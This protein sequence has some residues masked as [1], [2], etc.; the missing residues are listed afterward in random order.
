MKLFKYI[1]IF[2]LTLT[3]SSYAQEKDNSRTVR[4]ASGGG[5]KIILGIPASTAKSSPAQPKVARNPGDAGKLNPERAN[6]IPSKTEKRAFGPTEI[7]KDVYVPKFW[8]GKDKGNEKLEIAQ[9]LGHIELNTDKLRIEC[10]DFA[11]VDGDRVRVYLNGVLKKSNVLLD[12][13]YFIIELPL[14]KGFNKIDIQAI[15]QGVSGPNT[16]QF[17]VYDGNGRLVSTKKWNLLTGEAASL[18]VMRK[19]D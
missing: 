4:D 2:S 8:D 12:G 5:E 1:L 17:I 14:E 13:H 3:A 11:Y 7:P 9:Y 18:S 19:N 15:N 16:A 10:R 6:N